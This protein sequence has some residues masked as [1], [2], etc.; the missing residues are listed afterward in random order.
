MIPPARMART[1]TLEKSNTG[2]SFDE[3]LCPA[4][5]IFPEGGLQ[6]WATVAGAFLIQF[7]GFGYTTAF[8]VYQDFYTREYLT[9]SSTSAISWIGSINA[10]I[11]ISG[12][13]LAGRLYD[14]GYFYSLLYG[15]C[16]ILSFSI[17]MLSL[18]KPDKYYQIFLAQGL[19][20]GIGGGLFYVPSVAVV[21]HYFHER[22]ALAMGIIVAGASLGAVVHPIM[23]NNT[24]RR[25]GFATA[26]RASAGLVSGLLLIACLLMRARLPTPQ[27]QPLFWSSIR[28]FGRDRPYVLATAGL[29]IFN[30]GFF[31]PT[32]YLQLDAVTHGIDQT[33][34]FYSLVIMNTASFAGRLS[35][36]FVA[37]RL[38]I[39]NM[40]IAATACVAALI[41][42]MIALRTVAS[43]VVIGVLYGYCAGVY[44]TLNAPLLAVLTADLGELGLRLG[45]ALAA[46]G[47]G[48][49]IGPPINGALLTDHYVWW[50]PALFSGLMAVAGSCF[51]VATLVTVRR[52]NAIQDRPLPAAEGEP[53][54]RNNKEVKYSNRRV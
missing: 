15:G 48:G 25:L 39:L 9:H 32:F 52:Q 41:L 6:A 35:A 19:G 49:L 11:A 42:A 4:P 53:Y 34:S 16:I 8:G 47:L 37:R 44:V 50:R 36:G 2:A 43:V 14:R 24:L 27:A 38:G 46:S 51:F 12:G 45:V 23:L 7:C 17:F 20:A 26:V 3:E 18:C 33:F 54:K 31:F 13:L 22:R 21:S 28:R 1:D 30:M 29:T 10:T 40:T 5:A